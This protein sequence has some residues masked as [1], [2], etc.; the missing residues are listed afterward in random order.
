MMMTATIHIRMRA[1]LMDST[2][3]FSVA[4]VESMT[5]SGVNEISPAGTSVGVRLW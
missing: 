2:P 3:P 5:W 4:R 1:F